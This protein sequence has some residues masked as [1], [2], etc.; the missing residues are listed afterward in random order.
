MGRRIAVSWST[1]KDSAWALHE[2]RAAGE[3]VVGLFTSVVPAF[4]R[5]SMHGVRVEL[6]RAQADAAGLPLLE[7]PLPW[8][9]SNEIYE[10]VT[11]E[12]LDVIHREWGVTEVA[13]GD[14]FLA[15]VRAYRERLLSGTKLAPTFPL[16]GRDTGQLASQMVAAGIQAHVICVDPSRLDRAMAG[17]VVDA[18][19]LAALPPNVD[20]C[21]E[22]GEYHTFVSDGPMFRHALAVERGVVA[23]RDGFVYADLLPAASETIR[24]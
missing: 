3:A 19:F 7:A 5:V 2:L 9:C 21:G 15:D 6:A 22:R 10:R 4:R 1:G 23:E 24:G 12:A 14:L 13:F 17:R 11:L 16:W 8:P 18:G 20:A